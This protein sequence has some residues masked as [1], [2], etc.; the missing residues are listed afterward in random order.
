MPTARAKKPHPILPAGAA[1]AALAFAL[2]VI[3]AAAQEVTIT[4][5]GGSY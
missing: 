4:S 3:P 1:T 2:T 5:F